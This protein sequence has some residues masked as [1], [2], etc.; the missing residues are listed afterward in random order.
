MIKRIV[1]LSFEED[2]VSLFRSMFNEKKH[3]IRAFP[4]CVH[5]ELLKETSKENIFFTLS[6]W[7]SED[8]L[9]AYRESEL[10]KTTWEETK[11]LFDNKPQAWSM[12][13]QDIVEYEK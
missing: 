13:I 12:E 11:A 6:I 8:D 10:F 5:L 4:G 3:S 2:K 1:R 7:K 9:E